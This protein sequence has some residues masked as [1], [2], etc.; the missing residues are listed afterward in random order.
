MAKERKG[1]KKPRIAAI[2]AVIG[3]VAATATVILTW[4]A[5]YEKFAPA[6]ITVS[7]APLTC[8]RTQADVSIANMG[9]RAVTIESVA[10]AVVRNNREEPNDIRLSSSVGAVKPGETAVV[11][12]KATS[13]DIPIEFPLQNNDQCRLEIT[14]RLASGTN[15]Q[16]SGVSYPCPA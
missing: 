9:R 7:L 13:V 10:L 15:R 4:T 1:E 3:V 12:V 11:A 8:G 2:G 16:N 6:P 5:I 14:F